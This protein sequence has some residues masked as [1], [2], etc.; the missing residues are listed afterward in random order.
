MEILKMLRID[1]LAVPQSILN[2]MS[3]KIAFLD[4]DKDLG[5][6]I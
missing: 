4:S 2:T 1:E 5:E 6:I 3:S